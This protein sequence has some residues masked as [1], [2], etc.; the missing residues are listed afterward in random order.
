MASCDHPF[1]GGGCRPCSLGPDRSRRIARRTQRT[2]H[3]KSSARPPAGS[4]RSGLTRCP[5]C[6]NSGAAA[7]GGNAHRLPGRSNSRQLSLCRN[8]SSP[9]HAK[10]A[11]SGR[12]RCRRGPSR[13]SCGRSARQGDGTQGQHRDTNPRSQLAA[14]ETPALACLPPARRFARWGSHPPPVDSALRDDPITIP[15]TGRRPFPNS[16]Y[17]R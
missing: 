9:H 5:N 13:R 4:A 16:A 15:I 1:A 6:R 11:E 8:P 2:A 17:S 10:P 12:P 3:V 14:P 7:V